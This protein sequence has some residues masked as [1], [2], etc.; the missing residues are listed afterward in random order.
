MRAAM[1]A[2]LNADGP[3]TG[4]TGSRI[5]IGKAPQSAQLPYIV[6]TDLQSDELETM[7]ATFG[8][9]FVDYDVDCKA[10][11]STESDGLAEAV[12]TALRGYTGTIAGATVRAMVLNGETLD[13]EPP[14][15]GDD[16]GI[17]TVTVDCQMQYEP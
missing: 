15:S 13:F 4:Y 1:V 8:L 12:R 2:I 3:V 5:F 10:A 16:G 14:T 17:Y 7:D 11:S 9:R 6:I